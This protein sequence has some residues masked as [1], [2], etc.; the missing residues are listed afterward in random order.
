MPWPV[1][2]RRLPRMRWRDPTVYP[3]VPTSQ[4]R[5]Y[6]ALVDDLAV[7]EKEL[8]PAFV[9]LDRQ[10]QLDQN[11]FRRQQLAIF[12]GGFITAVFG[13]VQAALADTS[14]PGLVVGITGAAVGS[15]TL[16]AH[17][18]GSHRGYLH[19]R[20][21]AEQLRSLCFM[22][23]AGVGDFADSGQRTPKLIAAVESIINAP[24]P[25]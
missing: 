23:L 2:L 21:R 11:R 15:L 4:Q 3:P 17:Q 24:E 13:A 12:V 14:W 5:S 1:I 10:A 16:V 25:S 18:R 9:E 20:L 8:V 22:Y 7:L 19:A 6:P